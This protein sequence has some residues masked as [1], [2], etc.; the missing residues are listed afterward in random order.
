MAV[1]FIDGETTDLPQVTDELY[2]IKLY[3]VH[4]L[5]MSGIRTHNLVAIGTDW[6]FKYTE[7]KKKRRVNILGDLILFI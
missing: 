6:T 4:L 5:T 7:G 2:H 1:S 3:R